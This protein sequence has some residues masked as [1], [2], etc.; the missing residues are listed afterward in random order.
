[1][2]WHYNYWLTRVLVPTHFPR[3]LPPTARDAFNVAPNDPFNKP[4]LGWA[5]SSTAAAA[6]A[7]TLKFETNGRL[8]AQPLS[9]FHFAE[10]WA[11]IQ[12]FCVWCFQMLCVCVHYYSE[13]QWVVELLH[14]QKE[15]LL[16]NCWYCAA[17]RHKDLQQHCFLFWGKI[18]YLWIQ[19][20]Y[21]YCLNGSI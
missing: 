20:W 9:S 13:K 7:L 11:A 17:P 16:A 10:G 2:S 14:T 15:T 5:S 21:N 8:R 6:R 1:M 19:I 18:K 12:G 3:H 4:L